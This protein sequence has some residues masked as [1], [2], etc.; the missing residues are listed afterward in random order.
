[1]R[2]FLLGM[3]TMFAAANLLP[4]VSPAAEPS[5]QPAAHKQFNVL[6]IGN[7]FTGCHNLAQ[8]VKAMA[9]AGDPT[10]RFNVTTVLYGGRR[11]VDHWRLGTPNFVR[12][13]DLTAAEEQA[14]VNALEEMVAKDP[15]DK[16]ARAAL[17][18]HRE[19]SKSLESS[20]K[21]WDIVV[22]QS[23]RDDLE[24]EKSLYAQYAPKFADLI[25]AQ[26]G[27]VL[28]Y[29]TTPTTQN[30]KPLTA[31]PDPTAVAGKARA[32]AALANR[33]DATV[34]PMSLVALRCQTVR[35][36][37]PLR[38]VSDSHL[39]QTMGYL[40]ACTFYAALFNRSPEGL[41]IDTVDD[42]RG[43]N[44][45]QSAKDPDGGPL[46]RTFS[47]RDRADLQHIAW[48]GLKQFQQLAAS[49]GHR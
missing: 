11:L 3:A 40:T 1:M 32:I 16:Y 28:L 41:P 17:A 7:S 36:D 38:Y 48:E 22:L 15:K 14:T 33:I 8:V 29:E 25:K 23:Y 9:E 47:A 46:K 27:H 4:N 12:I 18:R 37:L 31:P 19:L 2:H 49:A 21:K 30:S 5:S 10:L 6:F 39:N 34:V 13:A 20:R 42:N 44:G 43:K 24:G 45:A 35:P 26:G